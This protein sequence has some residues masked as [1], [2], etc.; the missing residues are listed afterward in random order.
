MSPRKSIPFLLLA[1]CAAL[2]RSPTEVDA[3]LALG[4]KAGAGDEA[5]TDHGLE[6]GEETSPAAPPASPVL[7][8]TKLQGYIRKK[9][10]PKGSLASMR[11]YQTRYF[12]LKDDVFGYF[13]D[14][15]EM[16]EQTRPMR[17][18]INVKDITSVQQGGNKDGKDAQRK[19]TGLFRTLTGKERVGAQSAAAVDS[20]D[21]SAER[22]DKDV[23]ENDELKVLVSYVVHKKDANES[24]RSNQPASVGPSAERSGSESGEEGEGINDAAGE[25][26]RVSEAQKSA[27]ESDGSPVKNTV[28]EVQLK[29]SAADEAQRWAK[30]LNAA[31]TLVAAEGNGEEESDSA[32][33]ETIVR[34]LY[35]GGPPQPTPGDDEITS[36]GGGTYHGSKNRYKMTSA[37]TIQLGMA[38]RDLPN[39]WDNPEKRLPEILKDLVNMPKI[40]ALQEK[41][42]RDQ[43]ATQPKEKIVKGKIPE[44]VIPQWTMEE[45]RALLSA[46]KIEASAAADSTVVPPHLL[47]GLDVQGM[48]KFLERVGYLWRDPTAKPNQFVGR[49]G[50]EADSWQYHK[51]L[52]DLRV[53]SDFG[54]GL[55]PDEAWRVDPWADIVEVKCNGGEERL[56]G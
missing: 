16:Q 46:D 22:S 32:T 44:K 5:A 53:S 23:D 6:T 10:K 28:R 48:L 37:G 2:L 30:A 34:E 56:Q 14:E 43:H 38:P 39:F 13:T 8:P 49:K 47:M 17:G 45:L 20:S 7:E 12:V 26:K 3:R 50:K 55:Y 54:L 35:S 9:T 29:F 24:G 27:N 18:V 42:A 15:K 33:A 31:R 21:A 25:E 19:K 51:D 36:A 1:L 11:S 4:S 40:L 41:I 52:A